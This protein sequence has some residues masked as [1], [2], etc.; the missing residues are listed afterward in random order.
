MGGS[1]GHPCPIKPGAKCGRR[2]CAARAIGQLDLGQAIVFS[3]GRPVAAEDAGGTDELLARVAALRERG[4]IGA[5]FPIIL[6]KARKPGQPRFVDLPTVGPQTIVGAAAAGISI[7]A[8]EA[9][10]SLLLEREA[11]QREADAGGVSVIGV[12]AGRG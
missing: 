8:V 12:R 2:S 7:V 9:G 5:S 6:A 10:E 11:L 4:L 3:G 1:L